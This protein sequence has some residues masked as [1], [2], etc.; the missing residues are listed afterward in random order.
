MYPRS[1]KYFMKKFD[2]WTLFTTSNENIYL[3]IFLIFMHD[4]T[5][6]ILAIF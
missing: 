4:L 2:K 6:A 3:K 5:S 1:Q